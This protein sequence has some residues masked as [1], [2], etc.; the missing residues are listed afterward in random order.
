M[1][2]KTLKVSGLSKRFGRGGP[3]VVD[4]VSFHLE[5]RE[6][7]ALVGPS[8]CGKTTILRLIAGFERADAGEIVSDHR[9][10][11]SSEEGHSLHV[12][13]ELRKVGIVF[14]DYALFPH[15][16]VLANVTFGMS[17]PR[18]T[19]RDRALALLS[20]V[21]MDGLAY[22]R[23][24]TLSGGQQ[25]RVAL[26]RT[27]AASPDL[28]LLDEPFSN[29]DV[30]LRKIAG[31]EVRRLLSAE[32][33][34]AI[35]VTHDREEALSIGDRVAVMHQGR[36]VQ[37]DTAENVFHHPTGPFVAQ[38]VGN[39]FR[40][41]VS[42]RGETAD[43]P[44]GQLQLNVPASGSVDVLLRPEQIRLFA[45]NEGNATGLIQRREFRGELQTLTVRVGKQTVLVTCDSRTPFLPG[46]SVGIQ[47]E[48]LAMV[49][50]QEV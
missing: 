50:G 25:Q 13:P 10:L 28:V 18:K 22:R 16:S 1:S 44:L 34:A 11:A 7:L 12:P 35:L 45:S 29:L 46:Q 43:G 40:L 32:G 39:A 14:Q 48:G 20:L 26:I 41:S 15:L 3:L 5:P 27:L 49:D 42:A 36:I 33:V 9:T 30:H 4:R 19:R 2:E 23:P 24:H 17:G 47:V 21:G 38:F 31:R 37:I 8:G 6:L